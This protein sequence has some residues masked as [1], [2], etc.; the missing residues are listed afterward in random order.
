MSDYPNCPDC[1]KKTKLIGRQGGK[2]FYRC[3]GRCDR[4]VV[5]IESAEEGEQLLRQMT[6]CGGK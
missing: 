2:V 3:P 5:K 4:I 6:D 1:G